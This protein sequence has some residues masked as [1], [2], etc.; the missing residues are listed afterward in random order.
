MF[1][2]CLL[3]AAAECAGRWGSS[4]CR[5]D[6][7]RWSFGLP[8]RPAEQSWLRKPLHR[9]ALPYGGRRVRL[10][11]MSCVMFCQSLWMFR[12]SDST[13]WH[14]FL[15]SPQNWPTLQL[16]VELSHRRHRGVWPCVACRNQPTLW[17]PTL[18]RQNS[19]EVHSLFFQRFPQATEVHVSTAISWRE[20]LTLTLLPK[21]A[22][23]LHLH[24]L[25]F[26]YLSDKMLN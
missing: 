8:Q 14:C 21:G 19:Q 5:R 13:S 3:C 4:Y 23:S 22:G 9:G 10:N 17:S 6:G 12:I 24:L 2:F 20:D 15:I 16:P 26:M 7:W 18:Q 11:I 25:R 1:V